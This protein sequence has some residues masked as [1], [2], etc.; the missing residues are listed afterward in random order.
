MKRI[1]NQDETILNQD[2]I[3]HEAIA[4]I[5]TNGYQYTSGPDTHKYTVYAIGYAPTAAYGHPYP[6]STGRLYHLHL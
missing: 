4:Y 3:L 6:A 2:E 1:L 5:Y